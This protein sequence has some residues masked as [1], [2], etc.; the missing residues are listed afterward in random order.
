MFITS[1]AHVSYIYNCIAATLYGMKKVHFI[2]ICGAGMSAVAKLLKDLGWQ[3]TGSDD[4]FYPPVSTY[5][6]TSGINYFSGYSKQNIPKEIDLIVIG[7]HANLVPEKN[8]EVEAAFK[9]GVTIKSFA[10]V[11][12]DLSKDNAN[13]VVAGSYGKSTCAAIL[14]WCLE[15]AGKKPSYLIGAIPET[16][17]S[18][19]HIGK[20]KIFVLEGDEYPSSNW[21]NKSKF[22]HYHPD[23][24]L[25]T[26]LAHDHINI[27]RTVS[28]Y[29]K[30]FKKLMNS[31]PTKG[32]IVAC[33]DGEGVVDTLKKLK[34]R[35]VFYG[36][37]SKASWKVANIKYGETTS[38]DILKNNKKIIRL[39]TQLLGTHNIE[40]ILGVSTLLLT[41]GL[42]SPKQLA[43]AIKKFRAINRRLDRKSEKTKIPFYEGFG[44]SYDKA[45]SAIAAMRLHFPDLKLIVVFEPH[46]FSWQDRQVLHWYDHVFNDADKVLI[47]K[48]PA[49]QKLAEDSLT[50]KEILQRVRKPGSDAVGFNSPKEGLKLLEQGTDS[51][52]AVLILTSGGFNGMVES[53]TQLLE[54]KFPKK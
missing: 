40:N 36:L 49:K 28:D 21:D 50:L 6:K 29:R 51:N 14:A 44:S 18:S 12:G 34:R 46:T 54:S 52:S 41:L 32:T 20:G 37:K 31:L 43:S 23:H 35:V 53:V 9:S 15:Y 1:S 26:S 24:I 17:F 48:P 25:L 47:Y 11:L 33:A 8:I 45:R 27:F 22:L 13:I 2:G 7:K 4:N 38:F 19:S 16:P 10:Q 42:I 39:H 5:L 30:P 3:V